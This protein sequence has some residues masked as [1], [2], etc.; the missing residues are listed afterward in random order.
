M[1][2][3]ER[4]GEREREKKSKTLK[5]LAKTEIKTTNFDNVDDAGF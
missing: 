2:A 5:K 4:T 1:R 3:K